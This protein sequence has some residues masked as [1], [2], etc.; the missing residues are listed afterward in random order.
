MDNLP[1]P[2]AGQSRERARLD[3]NKSQEFPDSTQLSWQ[4]Q[5]TNA[6]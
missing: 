1:R 6:V 3:E 4:T 2:T 5:T